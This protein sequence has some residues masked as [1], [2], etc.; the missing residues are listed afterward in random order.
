VNIGRRLSIRLSGYYSLLHYSGLREG[1][2]DAV[3]PS[4]RT[5][6]YGGFSAGFS[7]PVL[8]RLRVGLS[9]HYWTRPTGFPD[10]R[11]G[12]L[13]TFDLIRE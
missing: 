8:R 7:L 1:E 4:V 3:L 2:E 10:K 9:Y 11:D 5:D 13:V 12:H 6:R